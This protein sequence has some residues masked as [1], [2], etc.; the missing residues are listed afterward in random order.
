MPRWPKSGSG[1]R[2][3]NGMNRR[4]VDGMAKTTDK[5]PALKRLG[6]GR[7]QTRDERFTI[8]PQSGTWV[9]VDA[10][11]TDDLG[12]ALVRGPFG[13]LGAAKEA[14]ASARDA[15]PAASPLAARV[16]ELRDR[17][18]APAERDVSPRRASKP[19]KGA[20]TRP[21]P[22]TPGRAAPPKAEPPA[23]PR[24]IRA[25]EPAERRRAKRLIERL[26]EA[27]ASD[28]EGIVRRDLAG[29]V[30]AVA[31]LAVARALATLGREA[32]AAQVAR[33]LVGGRDEDLGVRW[34]L[35]DGDDRPINLDLDGL[36]PG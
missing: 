15:K 30:P 1:G 33:L 4:I 31:A 21:E 35:V 3:S 7:W 34:R 20:E 10:E 17:P 28:P 24:W 22:E 19:L 26:T 5:D 18:G 32:S 11:Q 6:G 14:I 13:S 29:N 12:L 8:E 25:L 16:A 9:V 36:E 2:S 23:E 27:G